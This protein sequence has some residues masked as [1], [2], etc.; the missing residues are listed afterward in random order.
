MYGYDFKEDEDF[1]HENENGQ[2]ESKVS[3]DGQE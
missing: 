1:K 2:D 3:G